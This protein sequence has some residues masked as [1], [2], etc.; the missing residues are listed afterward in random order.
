MNLPRLYDSI[1]YN[2]VADLHIIMSKIVLF[3]Q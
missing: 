2:A 1:V 3:W